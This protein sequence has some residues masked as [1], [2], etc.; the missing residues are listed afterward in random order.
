MIATFGFMKTIG[1]IGGISWLSTIEYYRYVNQIVNDR[2]GGVNA[3]KVIIYSVN[4]AEIKKLTE[5]DDWDGL[6]AMVSEGA[7]KLEQ[8]GADC[9]LIGAN[10]MHKIADR[11]Q[12][13]V[14]VPV[15]HVAVVTA[16]AIKKQNL[17]TIALLGTKYVMQQEFYRNKLSEQGINIL[18]PEQDAIDYINNAIYTEFGKGI[19][20]PET[21]QRFLTI[22]HKLIGEGAEGVIF[23]CTEIPILIRPEECS[24]PVFDTALI[25]ATAA[26]DLALKDTP[27]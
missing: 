17:K 8:A 3:A 9:L 23:G 16:E 27:Y 21:K 2:L 11:V 7:Q 24:I 20:L 1:I 25:H 15:I 19:F 18:I 5:A 14:K 13:A 6:A 12:A 10:T 22:I 4:F 26:V